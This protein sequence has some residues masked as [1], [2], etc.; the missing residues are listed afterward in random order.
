MFLET[1]HSKALLV[2]N[3]RLFTLHDQTARFSVGNIFALGWVL[4]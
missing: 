3:E 4:K 2:E 1:S